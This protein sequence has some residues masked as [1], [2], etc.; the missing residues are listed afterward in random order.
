MRHLCRQRNAIYAVIH[1][2]RR[3]I[4]PSRSCLLGRRRCQETLNKYRQ[5]SQR[6]SCW[7]LRRG[8]RKYLRNFNRESLESELFFVPV[9]D[10]S[11]LGLY[12]VQLP[13]DCSVNS[14]ACSSQ[15]IRSYIERLK[16][17]GYQMCTLAP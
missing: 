9:L 10:F 4:S 3:E 6:G 1:Q 12:K 5:F 2:S 14:N 17:A 11:C 8:I 7:C 15:A 13:M 16:Q